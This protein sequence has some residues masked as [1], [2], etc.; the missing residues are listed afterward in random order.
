MSRFLQPGGSGTP[1]EFAAA[2]A[3]AVRLLGLPTRLV[4][5]FENPTADRRT[6][7]ADPRRRR[8]GVGRRTTARHRLDRLPP[9]TTT[10]A[11][12]PIGATA[13]G[14]AT[15]GA[16]PASVTSPLPGCRADILAVR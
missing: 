11:T 4:I 16:S 2:F 12:A 5:G 13:R 15:V 6:A 1:V 14:T 3:L 9:A 7:P 10:P 8:P